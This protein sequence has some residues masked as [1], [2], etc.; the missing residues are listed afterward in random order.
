MKPACQRGAALV[1]AL[2]MMAIA[3][4]LATA[5][6]SRLDA[7]LE[8]ERYR[9]DEIA[10]RA[11]AQAGL[12]YARSVLWEDARVSVIDAPGEIW[13]VPVAALPIEGGQVEGAISDAQGAFN[14]NN[15]IDEGA[16]SADDVAAFDRLVISLGGPP[17]LGGALAQGLLARAGRVGDVDEAWLAAQF[18]SEWGVRLRA[19]LTAL[20]TRTR[21]NINTAPAEVIAAYLPGVGVATVAQALQAD[22]ARRVFRSPLELGV[23]IPAITPGQWSARFAV[24]SAFFVVRGG[25]QVGRARVHTQALIGRQARRWPQ[26]VCV[27]MSS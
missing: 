25:A 10:A 1:P 5:L 6:A 9:R 24:D 11:L 13:A 15:L 21:V 27:R 23:A 19:V 7:N 20:P 22:G 8:L 12:E 2:L 18:A 17:G 14:L 26:W 3:A 4:S 16:P